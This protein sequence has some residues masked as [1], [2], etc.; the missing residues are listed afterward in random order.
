MKNLKNI[1]EKFLYEI[2]KNRNYSD[3]LF[4]THGAQINIID[5]GVQVDGEEGPDF[6]NARIEVGG[7]KYVG[8]VE[9]DPSIS[10][11]INHGHNANAKYN[12]VVLHVFFIKDIRDYIPRT[13]AGR[14]VQCLML[15]SFL[16]TDIRTS[17]R[18]AISSARDHRVKGIACMSAKSSA[19]QDQKIHFIRDLGLRRFEKKCSR[20]LDRLKEIHYEEMLRN[21][22]REPSIN[23]SPNED[24]YNNDVSRSEY[25]NEKIWQQ[26]FYE[27]TFEA[28]GYSKNKDSFRKIAQEIDIDFLQKNTTKDSFVKNAE[29]LYLS[30][31]GLKPNINDVKFDESKNYI[32]SMNGYWDTVK[33]Y[34]SGEIM[35]NSKWHFFQLKPQNFPTIRM[36]GG[37]RIIYEILH[38]NLLGRIM[39]AFEQIEISSQMTRELRSLVIVKAS[40]FWRNHYHF[41]KRAKTPFQYFIGSSRAEEIVINV[42][43][44][45]IKVLSDV[46][47]RQK[48]SLKVISVYKTMMQRTDNRVTVDVA[49]ALS[50]PDIWKQSV[51]YQGLIELFREYCSKK[52]CNECGIGNPE[53]INQI[54][55]G[56]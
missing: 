28:L 36:A 30:I 44:P 42:V 23:Y 45:F 55:V 22:M 13:A 35:D 53:K 46:F 10:D 29:F 43:L 27:L 52:R 54:P 25:Q 18:D 11:W 32:R 19:T 2:W 17:I 41:D 34:Y 24:F 12:K 14:N 16:A 48:N 50:L 39:S 31:S 38:N 5:P 7:I 47:G 4:T 33:K 1:K 40:G 26:L 9:I 49:N 3:K 51:F 15:S 21:R 20:I 37:V 8:D 56:S 6:K